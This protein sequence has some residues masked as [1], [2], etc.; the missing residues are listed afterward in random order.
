MKTAMPDD[1]N[2]GRWNVYVCEGETREDRNLM[3][4]LMSGDKYRGVTVRFVK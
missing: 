1:E 4:H 3:W 2:L